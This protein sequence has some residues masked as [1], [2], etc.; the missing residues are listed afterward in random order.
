M[1]SRLIKR[2]NE[3][4]SQGFEEQ[5]RELYEEHFAR[6]SRSKLEFSLAWSTSKSYEGDFSLRGCLLGGFAGDR[7]LP[8]QVKRTFLKLKNQVVF[9]WVKTGAAQ[10][11]Q[12]GD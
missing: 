6:P 1:R 12:C 5:K 7:R 9:F 3:L 10:R 4:A 11:N 2:R 8:Q